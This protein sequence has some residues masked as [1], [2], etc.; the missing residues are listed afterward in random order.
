MA[1][2]RL[3]LAWCR[4]AVVLDTDGSRLG[5]VGRVWSDGTVEV[6]GRGVPQGG[7]TFDAYELD[8]QGRLSKPHATDPHY[9]LTRR[10]E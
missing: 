4:A 6:F 9:I 5:I 3:N 2:R 7:R 8:R 1:G 10:A